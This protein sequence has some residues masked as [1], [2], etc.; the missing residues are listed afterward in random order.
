[1]KYI[2][3]AC[4]FCKNSF[5]RELRKYKYEA[6][7][8]GPNHKVYC[9]RQCMSE[10]TS[11]SIIFN[12]EF[13]S[14]ESSQVKSEFIKSEHHFCSQ[15]CAA[16]FNNKERV[17]KGYT[18]KGKFKK[19]K[20]T[21]CRQ[22]CDINL[23]ASSETFICNICALITKKSYIGNNKTYYKKIHKIDCGRCGISFDGLKYRKY[24]DKCIPI[25]RIESSKKAGAASALVQQRRSKNEIYFAELCATRFS[26]IQ[27]NEPVFIDKRGD[28]WDADVIIHDIKVAVLWN[29]NWHYIQI[30]KDSSL[31]QIQ[32]RD[33]IKL[34]V[35]KN[36]GYVPYVIEDRGK[37]NKKFVEEQFEVFL[38]YIKDNKIPTDNS[39]G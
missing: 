35:I 39:I 4:A 28:K 2:Q 18:A 11:A 30:A 32:N 36:N 21:I 27:C 9:S 26:N 5:S 12:C 16:T 7:K 17:Q 20:C 19:A 38:N 29:G 22:K 25:I 15:S 10:A 34:S 6:K 24:C 31:E 8:S 1:M 33:K 23:H 3:L 37:E 14:K 13:C